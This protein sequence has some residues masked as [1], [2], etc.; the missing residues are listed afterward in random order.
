[1]PKIKDLGI[2]IVPGTMRP[3][4]IGGGGGCGNFFSVYLQLQTSACNCVTDQ[5]APGSARQG[6]VGAAAGTPQTAQS[7]CECN[8]SA[9]NCVT[10]QWGGP[11]MNFAAAPQS[12]ES[13]CVCNPSACNCVTD[14]WNVVAGGGAGCRVVTK[15]DLVLGSECNC[16]TGD[17]VRTA[18]CGAFNCLAGSQGTLITPQ[19][20]RLAAGVLA[21]EDIAKLRAA[22]KL[23]L[24]NLDIAEKNSL[25]KTIEEIDAREKEIQRELDALKARRSELKK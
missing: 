6:F 19:T 14:Q 16:V 8:T 7:I 12:G 23:G 21:R 1:M 24:E 2:N 25:P 9:C 5:C 10:D 13:L 17:P 4:E 11:K 15:T 18:D 20:P 22:L 3:P